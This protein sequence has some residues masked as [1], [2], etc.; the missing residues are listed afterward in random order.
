[1]LPKLLADLTPDDIEALSEREVPEGVTL[2]YKEYRTDVPSPKSPFDDPAEL[3]K[4]ISALANTF[5]GD[6]VYGMPEARAGNEKLG[7]PNKP[8]GVP[9]G[10]RG[11]DAIR[12]K[13]LAAA[14]THV[15]PPLVGLSVQPVGDFEQGPVIVVRVPR[16]AARPHAV[17]KNGGLQFWARSE[18]GCYP[19]AV[20]HLRSAFLESA[21]LGEH[22]R[23]FHQQRLNA[24]ARG[25]KEQDGSVP[26][27]LVHDGQES[28]LVV[29][30]VSSSFTGP[31]AQVRLADFDL[32]KALAV[33]GNHYQSRFNADG[34]VAWNT[35][36]GD[37]DSTLEYLQLLSRGAVEFVETYKVNAHSSLPP[38]SFIRGNNVEDVTVQAVET[39]QRLCQEL[40]LAFPLVVL[41]SIT[42]ARDKHVENKLTLQAQDFGR[43]PS[44]RAIRTDHLTLPDVLLQSADD[45]VKMAMEPA[46][47]V[48]WQASGRARRPM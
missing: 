9:R 46:F 30:V 34:V 8:T 16:S 41:V 35:N 42:N 12:Q 22:A 2:E 13:V 21:E 37:R 11:V 26:V 25:G 27:S 39:A 43:G 23:A 19:M 24:I 14:S 48:M 15:E 5:G 32:R 17:K 7:Y 29:H 31:R 38:G 28:T 10:E 40:E 20:H 18:H 4:D 45:D 1:M 33:D 47:E 36:S 3:A 6:L 44:G